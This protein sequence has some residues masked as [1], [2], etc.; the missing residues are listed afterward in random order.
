LSIIQGPFSVAPCLT[1][2]TRFATFS[3][4]YAGGCGRLVE[5]AGGARDCVRAVW[6]R[7]RQRRRRRLRPRRRHLHDAVP[8][9]LSSA[10][11]TPCASLGAPLALCEVSWRGKLHDSRLGSQGIHRGAGDLLFPPPCQRPEGALAGRS[12][13]FRLRAGAEAVGVMHRLTPS[14]LARGR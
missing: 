10:G 1:L 13:S 2:I 9:S 5:L 7:V 4:P 12:R 14:N 6:R 8:R 11:T 3:S